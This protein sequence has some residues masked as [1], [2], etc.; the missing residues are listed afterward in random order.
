MKLDVHFLLQEQLFLSPWP[1]VLVLTFFLLF[2][3]R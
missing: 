2:P 3:D 1:A